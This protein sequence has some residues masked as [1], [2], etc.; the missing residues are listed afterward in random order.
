GAVAWLWVV[1]LVCD[2]AADL[3][4]VTVGCRRPARDALW[5]AVVSAPGT[6]VWSTGQAVWQHPLAVLGVCAALV[7]IVRAQ[8]DAA[9]AGRAGLPLAL[10]GA[11][12]YADI[13]LV[14]V[15]AVAIAVR[16]PRRLPLLILWAAPVVLAVLAYHQVYFGSPLR[17]GLAADRFSAPWGEGQLGLLMSPAKGLLVF[18]PVVIM[19]A[20]GLVRAFRQGDRWLASACGAAALAHWVLVGR[21]AEWHGGESWGPRLMTDA[22]PLLFLFLPE[23]YDLAPRLTAALA[24]LSVAV[25]ALGAF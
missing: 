24:A 4:K 19:A 12:R 13:V 14:G 9:W 17:Q 16:W 15:L 10:A 25:Q 23:G 2:A 3:G 8:D 11:A 5:T 22:L 18:T 6:T 21:W 1:A 7:C 20:A